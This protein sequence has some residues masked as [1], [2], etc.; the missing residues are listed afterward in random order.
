L[1]NTDFLEKNIIAHRGFHNIQKGIPEDSLKAFEEAIKN[2]YIIELDIHILKDGNLVV[3]HD[4]NLLRMTGVNKNLKDC[5]YKEIKELKLSSTNHNI[6]LF[7]EVLNLV[8]GRVPIIIELKVDNKVPRLEK[9][10]IDELKNYSGEYAV[11]SFNPFSVYWFRKNFPNIIRGQLS[12]NFNDETFSWC[13]KF[14]LKNMLLNFI[15]KP[16]FISYNIDSLPNNR[17]KKIR[18]NKLVLG[19]TVMTNDDYKYAKKYCD[20]FICEDIEYLNIDKS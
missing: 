8:N 5:T 2:N 11:K 20:N 4:D 12:C 6:P 15:T 17:V 14:I 9:K 3:F 1:R 16:D 13:K 10:L 7:K 19:W 18:K